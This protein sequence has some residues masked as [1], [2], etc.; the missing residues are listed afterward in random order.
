ML[1]VQVFSSEFA[2]PENLNGV[3]I[4]DLDTQE[5][6]AIFG[7]QKEADDYR[8]EQLIQKQIEDTKRADT[9]KKLKTKGL[10][11]ASYKQEK[12]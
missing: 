9:I 3:G 4:V 10:L 7:G 11:P 12:K 8:Y 1:E 5:G 2:T 6:V